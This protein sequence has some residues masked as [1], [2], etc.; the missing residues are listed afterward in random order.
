MG[1]RGDLIGA[2]DFG[3]RSIRVLLGRKDDD[4][5]IEIV[6]HGAAPGRGCVSQGVI[7]DLAAAQIALKQALQDAEKEARGRATALFCGVHG[8]KVETF[9]REGRVNLEQEVVEPEH[10]EEARDYAARDI[11][12]P[13]K[14]ITSS[15][16]AQEWYVDEL[17]VREPLGI[18]GQVLK[19]RIHFACLPAVIE[20]NLI[21]CVE[22]QKRYLEDIIFLPLAAALGTMTPEDMELGAA[23]LDIGRSTT[24]LAVYREH[25]ILGSHC[26]EW[27]GYHI[28]RDVAAGLQI[29][30][31]EAD[32]LIMEYGI[33]ERC[34]REQDD[35]NEDETPSAL[36][37]DERTARIKLKSVVPGAPAIVE[38]AELD[39][40]IYQRAQE[41][42]TK[43]RQH[44]ES[45]GLMKHLVR[46]VI[47]T[48]GASGIKNCAI[49]AESVFHVPCR[50]GT[51]VSLNIL[52][53]AVNTSEYG[54]AAG[55]MRHAFDY[56]TA[57][58]NGAH[59]GGL[60]ASLVGGLGR[61]IRKYFF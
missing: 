47:L 15:I 3:A 55:I 38:R 48:G 19:T 17:R 30:F 45:R 54:P 6:G 23:V 5:T 31:E 24:G 9:I 44:L 53:H 36:R 21:T 60:V 14:R 13:G 20:E 61:G 56:R 34:L 57:K 27:G 49:M 39:Y 33:S 42:M 32:D 11:L 59:N 46:G 35:E 58:R 40:I 1:N 41:L 29:S 8:K 22:S 10:L 16:T 4:G 51:P 52:P 7:Q 12:S 37:E 2:V 43:V 18:R 28:T 25:R 50:I 26:F